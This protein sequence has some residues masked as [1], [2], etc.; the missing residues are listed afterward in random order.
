MSEAQIASAQTNPPLPVAVDSPKPRALPGILLV[1]DQELVREVEADI[2]EGEGYR[3]FRAQNAHEAKAIFHR[4]AGIVQLLITDV[5]LPG[6]NGL[7]L[8]RELRSGSQAL[9]VLFVSGFAE[10][11]WTRRAHLEGEGLY[12]KKPFSAESLVRVV[13]A[14]AARVEK[15]VA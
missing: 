15:G 2:L 4:Y 5:V 13:K 9:L 6:Q 8:A 10:N 11:T 3:V 1:E 12:L 7:D 14:L